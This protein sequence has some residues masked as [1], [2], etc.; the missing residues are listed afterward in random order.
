MHEHWTLGQPTA[1]EVQD[2]RWGELSGTTDATLR[3]RLLQRL[4]RILSEKLRIGWI[5]IRK[6]WLGQIVGVCKDARRW[7]ENTMLASF[8]EGMTRQCPPRVSSEVLLHSH[9]FKSSTRVQKC[10]GTRP[11][12][13]PRHH[14]MARIH[15]RQWSIRYSCP[16]LSSITF[17]LFFLFTRSLQ[18]P[19]YWLGLC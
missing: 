19:V 16:L 17:L 15:S 11:P 9:F 1:T 5:S 6:R 18:L 2:N 10:R 13:Q 3:S 14:Q 4:R 12:P 7:E 8:K